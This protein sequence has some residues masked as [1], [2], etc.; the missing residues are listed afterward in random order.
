[1]KISTLLKDPLTHFLAVGVLLFVVAS[2]V[3]PP[4]QPDDV[5][6]VDR[7]SI[8]EFVQYRSKAF[9]PNAAA[10]LFDAM[11]AGER[12]NI[13][14]DFVREE[15]LYREA[16]A[17]GLGVNDYVI[18]QRMVQK[19]EFLAEAAVE[20][21]PASED[22]L[23]RFYDQNRDMFFT[24]ATATFTHVFMT[25]E[26]RS[27]ED[28]ERAAT[29]M[30]AQLRNANAGFTDAVGYGERFLFHTNYVDRS[31]NYV[32]SQMGAAVAA[33]V[34]DNATP[35]GVWTGPYYSDYGAHILFIVK[36]TPDATPPYD[37]IADRVGAAFLR[38]RRQADIDKALQAIVDGYSV[39]DRLAAATP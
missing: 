20:K 1:M 11:D 19:V 8:L 32:V 6:V 21:T 29:A 30:L 37:D 13:I 4:E 25:R 17:L 36:R 7:A 34:F 23:R 9:E 24:P 12:K 22:E 2:I 35:R 16:K 10:A 3:N 27:A 39:D 38:E 15:A 5:I 26:G 18:R 31:F 28:L 33:A 14:D